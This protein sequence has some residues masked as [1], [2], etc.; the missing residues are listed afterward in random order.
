MKQVKFLILI[1]IFSVFAAK[2]QTHDR[3]NIDPKERASRMVEELAKQI[4]LSPAIQDS[5][6]V[7]F[8]Y[9]FDDMKKERESGNHP[10]M[11]KMESKRDLKVKTLLTDEQF[12]AYQKFM[13]ERKSRRSRPGGE[14][15]PVKPESR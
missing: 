7:A 1:F 12:I 3:P 4:N 10:D 9:F 11:V 2:A 14:G 8:I 15:M 13:E 5:L 6:K